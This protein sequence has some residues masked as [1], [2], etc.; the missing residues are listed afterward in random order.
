MRRS[1]FALVVGVTILAAAGLAVGDIIKL[2]TGG[3]IVGKIV[4]EDETRI[5]VQTPTGRTEIMRE[6]IESI[7]RGG[8]PVDIYKQHLK[9]IDDSS[10]KDH[11]QLGLWCKEN[12]LA[13]EYEKH[14][15]R[16]IELD[17]KFDA[18][19]K[20]LGYEFYRGKWMTYEDACTAKGWVKYEGRY[21]PPETA[22]RLEQGLVNVEGKWVS[23]EAL[24]KERSERLSTIRKYEKAAADTKIEEVKVPQEI[25]KLLEMARDPDAAKRTAAYEALYAKDKLAKD[26]LA[27][28]LFQ[29]R[30][31][32]RDKVIG[33]FKSN[34]SSIRGKLAS[35]VQ[36]RRA[37]AL[38]VIFDKTIYPDAN[39]GRSGQPKVDEVVDALRAVYES[40][41]DYYI[42]KS[43]TVQ[44]LWAGH[45]AAVDL[46]NK[47]TDARVNLEDDKKEISEEVGE[48]ICMWKAM[49]SSEW[50]DV[51]SY[52]KTVK[53]TL[54]EEERACIDKTNWYRMMLGK[55]PLKIHEGL[56]QAARKHSECMNKNNFFAHDCKIHGSPAARCRREGAP[57]RGENIA[58]GMKSGVAAFWGWYTSSGHHRNMLAGHGCIGVGN[59]DRLWNMDLG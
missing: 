10:A 18:P 51:L 14:M 52:N 8:D 12:K 53:T 26:L 32:T 58:N 23:K 19:H 9:M 25:E 28:V 21:Y 17:P 41:F 54:T 30:A 22:K 46:V 15:L 11:Y 29:D 39:H 27:K 36:E 13:D 1:I 59:C 57:F 34:K 4:E 40:P 47:Y 55:R 35:I 31:K 44:E 7:E 42:E 24:E 16:A 43:S 3:R 45:K 5:I 50:I 37:N 6:D 20:E 48:I 2:N 33:Y 49:A 38:K 56:V